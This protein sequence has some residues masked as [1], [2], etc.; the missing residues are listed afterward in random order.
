MSTKDA[1]VPVR[2][3]K[4]NFNVCLKVSDC[5]LIVI[6]T[7]LPIFPLAIVAVLARFIVGK[8]TEFVTDADP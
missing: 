3:L 8:L 2:P 6:A 5:L 4:S 1:I 7:A